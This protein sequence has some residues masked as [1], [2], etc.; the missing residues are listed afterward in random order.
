M[1]ETDGVCF[2]KI[3]MADGEPRP[4]QPNLQTNMQRGTQLKKNSDHLL[5]DVRSLGG[6]EQT[7]L[8]LG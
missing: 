3:R 8:R 1:E 7:G 6:S 4:A 5:M 2:E